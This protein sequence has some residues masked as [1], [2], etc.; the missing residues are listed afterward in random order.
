MA[1]L[2]GPLRILLGVALGVGRAGFYSG[3]MAGGGGDGGG[4]M[5]SAFGGGGISFGGGGGFQVGMQVTGLREFQRDLKRANADVAKEVRQAM[6]QAAE[7]VLADA[8]SSASQWG[9]R[10]AGGL[11]ISVTQSGVSVRQRLRKTT[12]HHPNFGSLQMRDALEPAL[13]ANQ[14]PVVREIERAVNDVLRRHDL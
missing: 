14:A 2:V 13:A 6:R 7:P 12:G 5:L 9:T 1:F 10:T 4:S 8:R 11:G 3:R